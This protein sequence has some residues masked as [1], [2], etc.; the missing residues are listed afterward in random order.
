MKRENWHPTEH[1]WLCS[2]HFIRKHKSENPLSPD[3][4][5]S[6][7]EYVGSPIKRKLNKSVAVFERRMHDRLKREEALVTAHVQ[8]ENDQQ[9]DSDSVV[10]DND[11]VTK[12]KC[13]EAGV[14]TNLS[15]ERIVN[16]EEEC[17]NL[18]SEKQQ[19]SESIMKTAFTQESMSPEAKVHFLHWPA[20]FFYIN[21]CIQFCCTLCSTYGPLS[22]ASISAVHDDTNE[23]LSERTGSRHVIQVWSKS[24]HCI[25]DMAKV[26]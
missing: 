6:V 26:G 7:F 5:P 9:D 4:V 13:C 2:E 22:I 25:K 1:T 20:I 23:A 19:L 16:L 8:Q 3:Y 11:A 10:E 15:K 17:C 14:Q 18:R 24:V 12:S 21:G